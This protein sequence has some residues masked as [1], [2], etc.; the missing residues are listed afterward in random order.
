[1]RYN[2]YVF[3]LLIE[4]FVRRLLLY[5]CSPFQIYVSSSLSEYNIVG[6]NRQI[7]VIMAAKVTKFGI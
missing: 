3:H 4:G 5:F 1:M 7:S 6:M 2:I